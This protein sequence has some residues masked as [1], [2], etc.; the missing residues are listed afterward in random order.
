[1]IRVADFSTHLDD[2][3]ELLLLN[4]NVVVPFVRPFPAAVVVDHV[5]VVTFSTIYALDFQLF[6]NNRCMPVIY[7]YMY[8]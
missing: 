6:A 8:K 3:D 1:M 2:D 7:V 5:R 4:V